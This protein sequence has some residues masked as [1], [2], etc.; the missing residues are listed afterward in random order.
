MNAIPLYSERPSGDAQISASLKALIAGMGL[1]R[2]AFAAYL[3]ISLPAFYN[4]LAGR[5]PWRLQ[6]AIDAAAYVGAE[7][8]ELIS[9]QVQVRPQERRSPSSANRGGASA[10]LS[11]RA[12][13]EG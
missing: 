10:S 4:K 2:E 8:S 13:P 12:R 1:D 7:L 11:Q 9:G 3:G 6:E 5:S